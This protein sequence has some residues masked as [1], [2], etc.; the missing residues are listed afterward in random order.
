MRREV[1]SLVAPRRSLLAFV[2]MLDGATSQDPSR[3][4][5][6][7][8]RTR[9]AIIRMSLAALS[10]A[11]M[12]VLVK[13]SAMHLPFLVAVFFRTAVGLAML[14]V[15]FRWTKTALR[16]HQHVLLLLRSLFGFTA[17]VLFFFALERLP[18]SHAVILNFSSPI[19]VVMLSGLVLGERRTGVIL[20]FVLAAFAGAALLV[21]PEWS[22]VRIEAILGLL[23]ALFA[24]LAYITVRRLSR[25][26][27]SATIVFYFT[28]YGTLF[29][30]VA[31][32]V[33]GI[34]WP[35]EYD[36]DSILPA[37]ANPVHL[38]Y[39]L[40]VG[41]TATIG[42]LFLTS[43]YAL[44]RASV[45]SIFSYLNPLL[46]YV[47]GLLFFGEVPTVSSV[48]GGV[49]VIGGCAG[50]VWV[51]REPVKAPPP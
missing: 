41:F 38:L 7:P 46:S 30:L 44:E 5:A 14:L 2:P 13:A 43:A 27:S 40:G 35:D 15:Y 24:A 32:L 10:F 34:V 50:V 29:G 11:I 16:A 37:V 26:E 1:H 48:L 39:L 47:L 8:A 18:L 9:V 12:G 21:A 33:A 51:V 22:E 36:W 19:F 49:L 4:F 23:S 25:T 42:Q 6:D 28:L 20:P 3:R 31:L 17:L 45:V